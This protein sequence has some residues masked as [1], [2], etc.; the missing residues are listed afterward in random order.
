MIDD[1]GDQVLALAILV[2]VIITLVIGVLNLKERWG[3]RE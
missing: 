3:N 2:Y 1:A